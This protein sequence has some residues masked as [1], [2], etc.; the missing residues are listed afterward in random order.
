[1]VVR[2]TGG[3]AIVDLPI[4]ASPTGGLRAAVALVRGRITPCCADGPE[5]PAPPRVTLW[6]VDEGVL[7]LT[8]YAV[9]QPDEMHD[10]GP[11]WLPMSDNRSML[12]GRTVPE[13]RWDTVQ[14]SASQRSM[15]VMPP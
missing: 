9:P 11:S 8:N 14:T 13:G 15:A 6:A 2:L 1:Q 10:I 5:D 12:L 7:G 3:R 4:G